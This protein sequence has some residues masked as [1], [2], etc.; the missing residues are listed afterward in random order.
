MDTKKKNI[1]LGVLIVGVVAMTVAFAALST[2]LRINGSANVAATSWN[3]HFYNWQKVDL[4]QGTTGHTNT[5]SSPA[6]NQLST[7]D[8]TNITKV[9]GVN[10]TLNQPG[11]IA[12]YTFE[13]VNDGSITARLSN[14]EANLTP[15]SNVIGYEVK[16]FESN[17]RTG[18]EVEY[19]STLAPNGIAYCYLQVEYN[20]VT[21]SHTP[22]TTQT[23]TQ[24][25]VNTSLSATWTWIQDNGTLI[26]GP[27]WDKYY[28][29][30]QTSGGS[31]LPDNTSFWVQEETSSGDKEVC[32]VFPSG[33]V[34]L[35]PDNGIQSEFTDAS[36]GNVTGYTLQ[37]KTEME[38][39][40][41]SCSVDSSDVKCY[42]NGIGCDVSSYGYV[43]CYASDNSHGCSINRF[44]SVAC[45]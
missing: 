16:C 38:Q 8:S 12:K 2:N 37:K 22:G 13:I 39:A 36:N 9:E 34:C 14:F 41:A 20:D 3:I 45:K 11:D 35:T 10:V 28:T 6:V 32:G 19:N 30:T 23:Y 5:A 27:V 40:G 29:Q 17:T 26:T 1:L 21:N 42:G 31:T 4:A 15:S 44:G 25:A 43:R 18:T 33:T 24:S 7:S